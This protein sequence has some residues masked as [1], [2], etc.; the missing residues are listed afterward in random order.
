M[1]NNN[2]DYYSYKFIIIIIRNYFCNNFHLIFSCIIVK[3]EQQLLVSFGVCVC[4]LSV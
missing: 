2:I 1:N 3:T 4:F